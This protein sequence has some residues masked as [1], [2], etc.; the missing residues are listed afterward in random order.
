MTIALMIY[1]HM[2]DTGLHN[3]INFIIPV[4]RCQI[5]IHNSH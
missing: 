4:T 5:T 3:A 2:P 1:M